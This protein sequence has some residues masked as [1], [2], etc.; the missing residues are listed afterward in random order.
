MSNILIIGSGSRECIIAKRLFEDAN[1][2]EINLTVFSM[3]TNN[4]PYL[5][6]IG[7]TIL[8]DKLDIESLK[9]TLDN[10]FTK[11][12]VSR[13]DFAIVG[14][15]APLEEG[16][17][18][19]LETVK[20]PCIGPLKKYA[21]IESSK[22]YARKF[23]DSNNL[24]EHSPKYSTL[25]GEVI[26][27]L[28]VTD[29]EKYVKQKIDIIKPLVLKK[30]GLCGGKGVIVEGVDFT[31]RETLF[32][33]LCT[34]TTGRDVVIEEKLVGEE[35]SLMSITDGYGN[36][37]NFPPIQDYKRL[38]NDDKGSNTGGMGCLIDKNNTLPFL[39]ENDI[40]IAENIN[41]K[42]IN[43]MNNL[44][45]KYRYGV[46]YRGILYGSYIKTDDGQ[47]YVIEFNSRFGDP[48]CIIALSLLENN[49]YSICNQI[50]MNNFVEEFRFSKDA[51]IG[52]YMVPKNY[53]N[54]TKEKFDIYIDKRVINNVIYGNVEQNK[55]H[56]YSLSS[57]SIL[58]FER[59]TNIGDCYKKVYTN[60][61][62]I[63]GNLYY[64]TD[65][66]KKYLSSYEQA[67]VSIDSG[68]IAVKQMKEYLKSTYTQNVMGEH[69]DFGGQFKLGSEVL[70]SSIDGV[71]T[72]SVFAKKILGSKA[73][74][75][76]GK[77]IV[78]HCVNDILV[79]GAYPLFFLDY[80]GASHLNVEEVT[81]FIKGASI[82]C[83]ENGPLPLIGGETAE[84]P[85]IYNEGK[86]DL[87][88]C[89]IGKKDTQFFNNVKIDRGDILLAFHSVSPHTNG[90][91]LIN[92][93]VDETGYPDKNILDVLLT[94][95]KSYLKEV[96]EFVKEFGYDSVK[97]MCHITGGGLYE[98]MS[99]II[100]KDF[101][102]NLSLD[103]NFPQ[104]C[105]YL[106]QKGNISHNEMMRVFNCGIGFVL[107]VNKEV[108]EK[109]KK[110][111]YIKMYKIFNLGTIY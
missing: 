61:R 13:P 43:G 86:T 17:A 87:V 20:I 6:S 31:N 36:I 72:K 102:I 93:I 4:N 51:M 105:I 58:Y 49:F 97:G 62:H 71:G 11:Y 26:E 52:I 60:I 78:N 57:R 100:P 14:P 38:E 89:I 35:F 65:I 59:G 107:I 15:E 1:K 84:M 101:N 9:F 7:N 77:D 18:D 29:R 48:E 106:K 24:Q 85:S 104:W 69:G 95:H 39:T 45:N 81:N 3:A 90:Y 74:I 46:G 42:I 92:K 91:S 63:S 8:V 109:V 80:F 66:G 55:E 73:F 50:S 54:P 99:R 94:P 34:L 111:N 103:L 82:A 22:M 96:Q 21:Q 12:S 108:A 23:M 28:N 30:D 83:V 76:L 44:K 19:Y 68:N 53:P 40:K 2:L 75:N 67:G 70:V 25:I 79:Q 41:K 47:I 16:F 110:S 37:Q 98:N 33:E 10:M 64:R 5:S 56:L 27:K 88:G 32:K